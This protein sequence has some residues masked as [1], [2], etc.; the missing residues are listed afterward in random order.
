MFADLAQTRPA[1]LVIGP[2][3]FFTDRSTLLATLALRH[4]VPAIYHF[5]GFA[6]EGG[7][8]SLTG[9]GDG[10]PY[11]LGVAIADIAAGMYGYTN[12]LAALIQRGR[13]GEG[14]RID[15]SM[16]ESMAEWMGFPMYYAYEGAA[17]PPRPPGRQTFRLMRHRPAPA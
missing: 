7:L 12:I 2:D 13:T 1:G 15:V 10:D 6:A 4:A 5:R 14:V 8:M 16:L 3:L 17:P 9:P 11:R